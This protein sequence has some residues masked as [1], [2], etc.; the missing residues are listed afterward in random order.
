MTL[1]PG[2]RQQH[3]FAMVGRAVASCQFVEMLFAM[4]ARLVFR[5]P[6]GTSPSGIE[7]L[8]R[9]FS[10]PG[11]R[12]LLSEL[13]RHIAVNPEFEA[14]LET[15]MDRRQTIVHRWILLHDWPAPDDEQANEELADFALGVAEDALS[16]ARVLTTYVH[17][18]VENLPNKQA[19][20]QSLGAGWL[21]SVPQKIARL[22][23]EQPDPPGQ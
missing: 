10:K 7:P 17:A 14:E 18:W 12:R 9:N 21:A 5:Y 1:T 11:I 23:I 6:A 19:E 20:L 15:L 8:E 16:F 3:T 22:T 4:C 2:E 13:K